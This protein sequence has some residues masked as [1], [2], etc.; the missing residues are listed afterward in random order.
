MAHL[1]VVDDDRS[2]RLT[3]TQILKNQ[4]HEVWSAEGTTEALQ[5]LA[6]HKID[7]MVSDIVMPGMNGIE[8]MELVSKTDPN[9]VVILIT[10]EPATETA[11]QAL[12]GGA[13]DYLCKPVS[14]AELNK[15]VYEAV[16]AKKFR[17][18]NQDCDD[19]C[20]VQDKA[21]ELVFGRCEHGNESKGCCIHCS[22]AIL[23]RV[24]HDHQNGNLKAATFMDRTAEEP[25]ASWSPRIAKRIRDLN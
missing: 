7:V 13:L 8:L 4:G 24:A 18:T 5:I 19:I 3:F 14:S 12:R 11:I 1:L 6:Q 17:D 22:L 9:V 2:I 20:N 15:V 16:H 23:R 21:I 10:G 25:G